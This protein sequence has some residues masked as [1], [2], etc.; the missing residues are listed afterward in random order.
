MSFFYNIDNW[1][2]EIEHNLGNIKD[3]KVYLIG[4]KIDLDNRVISSKKIEEKAKN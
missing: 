3:K 4:N 2:K 1:I